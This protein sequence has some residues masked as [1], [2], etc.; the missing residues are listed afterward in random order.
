MAEPTSAAV[1]TLI[2]A[3]AS[4]PILTF[5]GIPLGVRPDQLLVGFLGAIVA[6]GLLNSVPSTGDTVRELL[7]TTWR[8]MSVATCSALTAGYL[9]PVLVLQQPGDLLVISTPNTLGIS[10]VIGV[11][12]QY[13]LRQAIV[14]CARRFGLETEGAK[15]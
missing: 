3:S 7:R 8:R 5:F 13:F 1:A 10:F 11:G 2:G 12:A 9:T 4:V 15:P 6:I 14:W